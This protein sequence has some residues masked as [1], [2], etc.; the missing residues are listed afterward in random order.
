MKGT[1][2]C[3]ITVSNLDKSIPFYR[4][5]LGLEL[6]TEPTDFFGGDEL[7]LALGMEGQD[8]SLRVCIFALPDGTE[9]EL[10]EY[11]KPLSAVEAQMPPSTLGAMHFAFHVEDIN[12]KI[13]ELETKGVKFLSPPNV[14]T[15]GPLKGWTWIYFRDPD[16][17]VLELIEYKELQ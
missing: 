13:K 1:F 10:L 17:I 15:E 7:A 2:H 4:D 12:A 3:G 16:G 8:I 5:I 9:L 11:E 6:K 14:V